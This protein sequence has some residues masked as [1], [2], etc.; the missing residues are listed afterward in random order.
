MTDGTGNTSYEYDSLGRLT[1]TTDGDNDTVDYGYD[2]A[3]NLTAITYPNGQTVAQ[4]YDSD[5]RLHTIT[6]WLGNETQLD[7]DPDSNLTTTTFPSGSDDVDNYG[8]NTADQLTSVN[9]KHGAS[10]L[11]SIDYTRYPAG[12]IETSTDNGLPEPAYGTTETY[13][14]DG[15]NNLTKLNSQTGYNYD[16][17]DE[18]TSS[19]TASYGY[20]D[21]GERISMTPTSASATD[22]SYDQAGSLTKVAPPTGNASNYAYDGNGVLAANTVGSS[23]QHFTWNQA[24]SAPELLADG[25]NSYIYG[26]DG[27]AIEQINNSTSAVSY[28]HH[29]QLG[30]T[31]LITSST[32][33]TTGAYTYTP[34]GTTAATTGTT[35]TPLQY[36]GQYTDPQ[37]GLIYMRARYYD[38]QTGQFLSSD[39]LEA[40]TQ[41][42]YAYANDDPINETDPTGL[43]G[44]LLDLGCVGDAIGSGATWVYNHPV[45][46]LG[47][48]AGGVSLATGV[49]EVVLGGGAV[50]EGVLGGV[51]VGSGVVAAGVDTHYCL[52]GSDVSCVGAGVGVLAT[53]GGAAVAL[54]VATDTAAS[55][56]TAIG[57][58]FG[59]I[60]LLGDLASAAKGATYGNLCSYG[61]N[62]L[63]DQN[64]L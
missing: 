59:G 44:G 18:L 34:Y 4:G 33:T 20:D 5:E 50:A 49:G 48:V 54:G 53:G 24:V 40:V 51:S 45:E 57:L 17:A 6:D 9:Y 27:L 8:Y 1:S 60:G 22:Y 61:Q 42:P 7:Y 10:S 13:Q 2:L 41:Q 63:Y 52:A 36:A 35:T 31:R 47:L 14:A 11:A 19:P 29:D 23:T 26:P 21:L 58:S 3:N 37:T 25:T 38:P 56:A 55:G 32:G 12:Q 46:T 64:G 39:P 62:G 15:A 16:N 30:S 43:C 28:L